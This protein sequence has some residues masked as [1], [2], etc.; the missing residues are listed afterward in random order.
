MAVCWPPL[1]FPHHAQELRWSPSTSRAPFWGA[2]VRPVLSAGPP[3]SVR[4]TSRGWFLNR[5]L[6][7]RRQSTS[8]PRCKYWRLQDIVELQS[9]IGGGHHPCILPPLAKPTLL[10]YYCTAIAQQTTPPRPPFRKPY[11]IHYWSRQY[12]VKANVGM[13]LVLQE[14]YRHW[15][16]RVRVYTEYVLCWGA[17]DLHRHVCVCIYIYIYIYICIYI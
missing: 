9:F 17:S 13:H 6:R 11:P 10:Q 2:R 7:S 15:S 3:G 5:R 8:W 1:P 14:S 16:G 12:R 4:P